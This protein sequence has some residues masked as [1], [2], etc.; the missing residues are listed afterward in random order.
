MRL[1]PEFRTSGAIA[2][3]PALIA[4]RAFASEAVDNHILPAV[5]ISNFVLLHISAAVSILNLSSSELSI[6][7]AHRVTQVMRNWILASHVPAC[8]IVIPPAVPISAVLS[9]TWSLE[10][11]HT[12]S[13]IHNLH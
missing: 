8:S 4:S 10:A 3:V 5:S 9:Y 6:P 1:V 7:T 11:C 12:V 13:P 2:V